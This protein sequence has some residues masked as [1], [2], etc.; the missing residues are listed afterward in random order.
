[1]ADN[2]EAALAQD[3]GPALVAGG[4]TDVAKCLPVYENSVQPYFMKCIPLVFV[5]KVNNL[6]AN[7]LSI[8]YKIT[9]YIK[10]R[11]LQKW[12]PL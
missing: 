4:E 10:S 2:R 5:S 11:P 7:I 3:V 6:K 9:Q 12:R 1:L 8:L